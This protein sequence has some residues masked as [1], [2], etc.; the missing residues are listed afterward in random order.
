MSRHLDRGREPLIDLFHRHRQALEHDLAAEV[1][2]LALQ[3]P[4]YRS[5]ALIWKG[6]DAL[7]Q[8]PQLAFIFLSNAAHL[9][10]QRADVHALVGRSILAQNQPA[11]AKRYLSAAWQKHPNDP[12]LRMSLWQARSLSESPQELRKSILAQL[13]DITAANEL[14]LVLKLLL[15]QPEAE[16]TVGVV[17]YNTEAKEIQGW[18]VDLRNLQTAPALHLEAN[19]QTMAVTASL[20]H[21]LL[22]AVGLASTHGGIRIS[23][24]NPTPAVQVR[25]AQAGPLLGSPV[26]AMPHFV[27]PPAL[28]SAGAGQ[29]VDVLIPVY[30]GLEETLECINSAITARKLNRTPHRIVVLDDATPLPAL[31][32]ALKVLAAKG[33]IKLIQNPANLGFIRNMNRAMALSSLQD[34][35]WLNADTRVHG[36]WLDRLRKK[37]YASGDIASVTPF[38]N[39]GELMSFPQSRV[40]SAMPSVAEQAELDNLASTID[41]PAV[42]LETGCGFCLYIKRT[43]L[44]AV[45]YLDEEHLS[46]G[47]GE[48][49]DWCLRARQLG[50]RH[51]GAANV[52]VAHKGGVSFKEEKL[53]RVAYNN[54]ILRK[55]FPAAEADYEAFCKRDPLQPARNALQSARF[56]SL[57]KWLKNEAAIQGAPIPLHLQPESAHDLTLALTYRQGDAGIVATLTAATPPLMTVIDYSLPKDCQTLRDHL[58][59][60][61]ENGAGDLINAQSLAVPD[62]LQRVLAEA[63]LEAGSEGLSNRAPATPAILYM[64]EQRML[65]ADD[66]SCPEMLDKWLTVARQLRTSGSPDVLCVEGDSPALKALRATGKVHGLLPPHGLSRVEWAALSGCKLLAT[67][68]SAPGTSGHC[69]HMAALHD[70]PLYRLHSNVFSE[71]NA[72]APAHLDRSRTEASSLTEL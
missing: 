25:F 7:P 10:P 18:A 26:S 60:L 12:T 65:V 37:A 70:L 36:D 69:L 64:P 33:K 61:V 6:I 5:E 21:P 2:E 16:G 42:E 3:T 66:L 27:A 44:D 43:A 8:D 49:T 28:S 67:L 47:Y 22:T 40:S 29:P 14:S 17:R 62:G 30:D 52:F 51:L 58:A 72:C 59:L 13:P 48:E 55:R 71:A 11:L 41:S 20:P 9:L 31:S 57:C 39:N 63:G 24:P 15:A 1:L 34:V 56:G 46:R 4:E 54:A 68:D 23:V 32:K 45:G 35:V 19:G 53:L 38:T 50:F